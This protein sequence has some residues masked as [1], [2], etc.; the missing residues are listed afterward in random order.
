MYS[1]NLF[2][3]LLFFPTVPNDLVF[4][5]F[6]VFKSWWCVCSISLP[7]FGEEPNTAD[8]PSLRQTKPS[9]G[10]AG[11][12]ASQINIKD[13]PCLKAVN[14]DNTMPTTVDTSAKGKLNSIDFRCLIVV[15]Y[16]QSS[17]PPPHPQQCPCARLALFTLSKHKVWN[18][19]IAKCLN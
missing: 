7:R 6:M 13:Q 11:N 8:W 2:M 5:W 10:P 18:Q 17:T 1:P 12:Q 14:K 9:Q 15:F 16:L 19:T 4:V 3:L